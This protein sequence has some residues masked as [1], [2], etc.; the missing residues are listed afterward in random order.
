MGERE[1]APVCFPRE[2]EQVGRLLGFSVRFTLGK[3]AET[4]K[5]LAVRTAAVERLVSSS[6]VC[7]IE[8]SKSIKSILTK[9]AKTNTVWSIRKAAAE[10][11]KDDSLLWEVAQN[12]SDIDVRKAATCGQQNR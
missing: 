3:I 1:E 4:A 7:G 2:R 11:L 12:A 5:H 9:I 8:T 6:S 10:A